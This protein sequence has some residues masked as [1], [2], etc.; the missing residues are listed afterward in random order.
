MPSVPTSG[1]HHARRMG[2]RR[3]SAGHPQNK[4]W[5]SAEQALGIRRTSAGQQVPVERATSAQ[6]TESILG[7]TDKSLHCLQLQLFAQ[8][9]SVLNN[10]EKSYFDTQQVRVTILLPSRFSTI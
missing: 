7:N 9:L 2:I 5:A 1:S 6:K 3:T 4:R 8:A 10:G